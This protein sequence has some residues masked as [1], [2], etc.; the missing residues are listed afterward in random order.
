[1]TVWLAGAGA[2]RGRIVGATD[3]LG[4]VAVEAVHT[5]ADFGKLIRELVA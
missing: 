1:M 3:E 5:T 2:P 4:D